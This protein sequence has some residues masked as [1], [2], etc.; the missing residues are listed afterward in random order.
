VKDLLVVDNDTDSHKIISKIIGSGDVKITFTDSAAGA[1]KALRSNSFD[2]M[3]LD[4]DLP[5]MPGI[6]L[7]E[8]IRNNDG[9]GYFPII[10]YT[11]SEL[12]AKEKALIDKY[13]ETTIVKGSDGYNKLLDETTLFLHRV[14]ANLPEAQQK[15]IR[16]IHDK[17]SLF[18]NKTVLVVDDD[19]RNVYSLKKILEAKNMKVIVG[20]SGIE[21]LDHLKENP[22]IALVLMDIMMPE[23]DGYAAMR[24]IRRQHQF[25][26]LPII[27]LT[28][29]A[30][31]GDRAKCIEAGASDY[32]AKPV[33]VDRLLSM[34]RVWLYGRD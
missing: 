9:I 15:I 16:M 12:T 24:E 4:L 20:K 25:K 22:G 23:M 7:M 2:G 19:M 8:K 34:L 5:D 31:K 17:E 21:A 32:L 3:I 29:K 27:A 30:M 1:Y 33:D 28:A 13:S 6:Q 14:E 11:G 10:V 18:V 26:D